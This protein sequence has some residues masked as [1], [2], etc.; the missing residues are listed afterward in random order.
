MAKRR[1]TEIIRHK[2]TQEKPALPVLV[3]GLGFLLGFDN[4]KRSEDGNK[5]EEHDKSGEIK[6]HGEPPG[7]VFR[8][9]NL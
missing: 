5:S 1:T 4:E 3:F 2:A 6:L 9:K 7:G 8:E